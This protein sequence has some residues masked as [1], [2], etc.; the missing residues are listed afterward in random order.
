MSEVEWNAL[1]PGYINPLA[2]TTVEEPW[3]LLGKEA[4]TDDDLRR[5]LCE[6]G[7]DFSLDAIVSRFKEISIEGDDRIFMSPEGILGKIIW[8]LRHS[9]A[10][11]SL[12]NYLGAIALCGL[13]VE[14]STLLMFEAVAEHSGIAAGRKKPHGSFRK[15][16]EPGAFE[17]L[18]QAQRIDALHKMKLLSPDAKQW[19]NE[20]RL[21]R[22]RHLHLMSQGTDDADKDAVRAFLASV[23]AVKF[24]LGLGIKDGKVALRPEILAWLK[25]KGHSPSAVFASADDW[26]KRGGGPFPVRPDA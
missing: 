11:Y 3:T 21:I 23:K 18:G 5:F 9:K 7:L 19:L 20:V 14:M 24:V 17:R 4:A 25:A 2:F 22:R 1:V 15:Y 26:I 12:G 6:P 8:P 16:F 13:V 10:S